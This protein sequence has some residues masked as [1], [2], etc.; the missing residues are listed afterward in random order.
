MGVAYSLVLEQTQ[1][2]IMT[3]ELR[4]AIAILQ[5]PTQELLDFIQEKFEENPLLD[6]DEDDSPTE[7]P[8]PE[9]E[10]LEYFRDTSD[11]GFIPKSNYSKEQPAWDNF[12][13]RETTL[14]EHLTA[15]WQMIAQTAEE[16]QIGEFIIGS[17]DSYG[18]VRCTVAEIADALGQPRSR[19]LR[20]LKAIQQL[21][22]NGVGARNLEECLLIQ[23]QALGCLTPEI[24]Q[25]ILYHLPDLAA[26]RLGRVAQELELSLPQVQEI[27]DFIRTL[28]PKPGRQYSDGQEVHYIVP[29]VTVERVQG[30]YVIL[31]NDAVGNRLRVNNYYRRIL[32]DGDGV[33]VATKRFVET[34]LN[35][36]VWLI[37]SIEQRRLTIYRIVETLLRLQRP[38]FDFGVRHLRPLT[39]RQVADEIGVH[40]STVSRAT[41][42]KFIQT[43]H[44][45][46]PLR[47][48]FD[49]GVESVNGKGAAAES[50]K[51]LLVDL[52]AQEDAHNPLSDQK[53]ADILMQKGINVSRR[54]VAKY[55]QEANIPSSSSRRRYQ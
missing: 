41:A 36:A 54:T 25:V 20:V 3:Q 45:V 32:S 34:K 1:K 8:E 22:S 4:Q 9:P 6:L 7:K 35:S 33:D 55:R 19:V 46:F 18:Y 21:E 29:D 31:V 42:N 44:G 50:V 28:D 23:T 52:V 16:K 11:L 39:L 43:T 15:D 53:L 51:R 17:L 30:E 14:A 10:W 40:E 12:L 48:L 2:L 26:G 37:R 49:S 13:S 27:R 38:F 24:R 47:I 5:M